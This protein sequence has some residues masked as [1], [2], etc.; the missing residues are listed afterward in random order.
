M[1]P[2]Q[3]ILTRELIRRA[4]NVI[5]IEVDRDLATELAERLGAPPNLQ[6]IIGDAR[7]VD[8]AQVLEA[9]VNY[10][11]VANLPYYASNPILRRFLEAER[12]PSRV[13]IMVQK[14]VAESMVG[15]AGGMSL[16]AVGVQVYGVPRIIRYVPPAAFYPRPKVTSAVVRIDV[17]HQ[18][19]IEAENTEEFFVMV[20]AGFFA[21]RKH[22]RNSLG[23]GLGIPA[24]ESACLI[25][26]A[27]LDPKRRPGTLTL[28]EWKNLYRAGKERLDLWK[29]M[30]TPRST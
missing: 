12:K 17:Y 22:L 6:V 24:A 2:G 8:L 7:D 29:S 10:K 13:V 9:D 16:L 21:P 23:L 11:L 30:P 18:S 1:G 14:E 25:Q 26:M 27:D 3:G 19:V 5:A 20:R 15:E 28:E 4:K